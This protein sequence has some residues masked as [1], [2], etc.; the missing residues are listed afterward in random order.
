MYS[1]HKAHTKHKRNSPADGAGHAGKCH[2]AHERER[3]EAVS[4][5]ERP[6]TKLWFSLNKAGA[7]GQKFYGCLLCI[8][9][10]VLIFFVFFGVYAGGAKKGRG[11]ITE[12][13]TSTDLVELFKHDGAGP[14]LI[15]TQR[16]HAAQDQWE[17]FTAL[18]V[19]GC[20]GIIV[21]ARHQV[22]VTVTVTKSMICC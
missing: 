15:R 13:K 11:C 2:V 6:N 19:G 14:L 22:T 20:H 4:T 1:K 18:L 17:A 10:G 5:G 12:T 16:V 21:A 9:H 3:V 7:L 8:S